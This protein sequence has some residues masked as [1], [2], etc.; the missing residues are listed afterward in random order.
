MIDESY[1]VKI[2]RD[3]NTKDERSGFVGFVTAFHV[4]LDHLGR[5]ELHEVGGRE[6]R[7]YW[8]PAEELDDFNRNLVG[9][10]D[11]TAQFGVSTAR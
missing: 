3:W 9:R 7:E 1:A 6:H 10:I 4:R 5:F 8:I 2:A 11:V